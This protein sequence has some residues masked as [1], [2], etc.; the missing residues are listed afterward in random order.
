[1]V[2]LTGNTCWLRF[3]QGLAVDFLLFIKIIYWLL[4]YMSWF[5]SAPSP[6]PSISPH[7]D[8]THLCWVIIH[9]LQLCPTLFKTFFH[10]QFVDSVHSH[11]WT[12]FWFKFRVLPAP[13]GSFLQFS[14]SAPAWE[15]EMGLGYLPC[16]ST[17][18]CCP[19]PVR[20]IPA[21][22]TSSSRRNPLLTMW[23]HLSCAAFSSLYVRKH[24]P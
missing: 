15:I 9:L 23:R 6:S 21:P 14:S 12:C 24:S 22:C 2:V 3:R 11:L 17:E 8:I 1:M 13:F 5:C 7:T 4:Q 20:S 19:S 16:Y 10:C 18:K